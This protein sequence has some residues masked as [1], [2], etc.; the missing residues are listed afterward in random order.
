VR[1]FSQ[2]ADQA[3]RLSQT[4]ALLL[5]PAPAPVALSASRRTYLRRV[6]AQ[7]GS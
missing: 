2:A 6:L 4:A 5:A 1:D 7:L 3:D